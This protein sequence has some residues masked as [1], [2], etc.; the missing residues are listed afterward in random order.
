MKIGIEAQ[1]IFRSNKHGMDFVALET[2]RELQKFDHKNEYF[3]F[4]APG[5]DM[6]LK[7][8]DNFHIIILKYPT[9]PLWEQFAL[10]RAVNKYKVDILHC[11]SNTAPI[12][13]PCPLIVTLHDI[14]FLEKKRGNNSSLYQNM[15]WLY[16]RYVVPRILKKCKHV[17]TVS[18]FERNHIIDI[19]KLDKNK[20]S[21]VY[22]GFGKYFK[23]D[24]NFLE[25]TSKYF[26]DKEYFFF[27]GNTD[28]KKN[29]ER[30]FKAYSIYHDKSEYPKPLIV[31]DLN[32]EHIN[33]ILNKLGRIDITDMIKPLGYVKNS[34]LPAIYSG[35]TAFIY[36]SLRESF[37]IPLLEGMSCGT[38]V[39]TSNIS[40]LPEIAGKGAILINPFDEL[41]ISDNM[42]ALE[43]KPEMRKEYIAKGYERIKMFSWENTA[44]N[45]LK[46]YKKI[47]D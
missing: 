1:R 41:E 36:A 35:S 44:K 2:I 32:Q 45:T 30:I 23:H 28:P 9:Y 42:L 8:S 33:I 18:N 39:I 43:N 25:T 12:N 11:T 40:A 5:E 3:I 20:I 38:P 31:A 34:D 46:L 21:T 10:P 47:I 13:C 6:C 14:I 4:V 26:P 17:I 15:G 19:L 22:N 29:T 24:N 37:G 7:E 16:R 27:L